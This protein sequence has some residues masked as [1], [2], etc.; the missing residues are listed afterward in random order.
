MVKPS[1][2]KK[3]DFVGVVAPSDAVDKTG[4][5]LSSKIVEKLG[6]KIKFGNHVFAKVGDFMA[7]TAS[8][9]MEDLKAMIYDPQV[10]VIWAASGGYAATEVMPV[11]DKETISYLKDHPKWFVGYSDICL[12]LNALSSYK[13]VSVTGPSLWGL[14]EWDKESQEMIRKIL[15]GEN[16]FGIDEKAHWRPWVCGIAEGRIL[17]NVLETL[18]LSFGT[19]FDPIM[20]GGGDIILAIEELDIDKSLLQRQIDTIFNHKKASR[21]K[22][23]IV[24]RLVNIKEI[25]YPEWGR[26]LTAREVVRLRVKDKG[27]PVAFCDDLGHAE[28]EYPPFMDIK[29]HFANRRFISLPNGIRSRLTVSEKECKLELLEPICQ[30]Q[31]LSEALSK[32]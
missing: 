17:F 3:G 14:S 22:G 6:L 5:I 32:N 19:R 12:L 8:E 28:W 7:G 16:I 10:K 27:I 21:I 13:I 25:S 4:V 26:K 9:R 23:L 1:A 31:E 30:N 15:F 18:I 29:K 2:V 24:G 11:F 20:Y